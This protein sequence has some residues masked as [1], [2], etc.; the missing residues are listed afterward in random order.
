MLFFNLLAGFVALA[1]AV[2]QRDL[3][4]GCDCT[5][6][7]CQY[8]PTS[9]GPEGTLQMFAPN[10]TNTGNTGGPGFTVSQ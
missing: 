10:G 4:A 6:P 3:P 1:V 5:G 8:G 2:E 7:G 9:Q